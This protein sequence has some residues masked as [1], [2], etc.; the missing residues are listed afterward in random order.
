MQSRTDR[1][2]ISEWTPIKAVILDIF[3]SILQAVYYLSSGPSLPTTLMR[4]D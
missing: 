1:S 3:D 4:I 2:W